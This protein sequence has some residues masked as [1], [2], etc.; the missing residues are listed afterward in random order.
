MLIC[1]CARQTS[2][3]R[4]WRW[5]SAQWCDWRWWLRV[6]IRPNQGSVLRRYHGSFA[7]VR[8]ALTN[9]TTPNH[10]RRHK[11]RYDRTKKA[12]G[13]T[14]GLTWFLYLAVQR[15]AA[16]AQT[17]IVAQGHHI[18]LSSPQIMYHFLIEFLELVVSCLG[19]GEGGCD[20]T[21]LAMH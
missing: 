12:C 10:G 11:K 17:D 20:C 15:L 4:Q 3:L 5:L 14:A 2:M 13:K 16:A 21:A 19:L 6:K 18:R 8:S 7:V 9:I 1:N